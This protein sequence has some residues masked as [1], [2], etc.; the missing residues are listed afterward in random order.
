MPAS[1]RIPHVL[2][3]ARDGWGSDGTGTRRGA[4][5]TSAAAAAAGSPFHRRLVP[6]STAAAPASA[7]RSTS[8]GCPDPAL[9][10][11]RGARLTRAP[12][13][14]EDR[15]A[16]DIKGREVSRVDSDERGV[17]IEGA[18]ELVAAVHLDQG[19]DAR[20]AGFDD[21]L[22]Q[23]VVAQGT[24]DEE[25]R[26][27]AEGPPLPHAVRGPRRSPCAAPAGRPGPLPRDRRRC[28]GTRTARSRSRVRQPLRRHTPA[29]S[30]PPRRSPHRWGTR[31]TLARRA[32][33]PR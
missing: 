33:P 13:D 27:G 16:V 18:I 2:T 4:A 19:V 17:G 14:R 11:D 31:R 7:T 15:V 20:F 23:Q 28:R 24:D 25:D 3:A 5:R 22:P 10:N 29:R 26:I 21:E 8:A 1:L 6:T 30:P 12:Q 32:W 9:G